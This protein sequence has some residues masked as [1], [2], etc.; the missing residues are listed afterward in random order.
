M[1]TWTQCILLRASILS[2][3]CSGCGHE[4]NEATGS[5]S[6]KHPE[7]DLAHF[8]RSQTFEACQRIIILLHDKRLHKILSWRRPLDEPLN[9]RWF[10]TD[11]TTGYT[12]AELMDRR[13]AF[14]GSEGGTVQDSLDLL[15]VIHDAEL[16]AANHVLWYESGINA[17]ACS[18]VGEDH[19]SNVRYLTVKGAE[20]NLKSTFFIA[21]STKYFNYWK[22]IHDQG[23]F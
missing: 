8:S 5:P 20:T 2:L 17:F 22:P 15:T 1:A 19:L 11:G 18:L 12:S 16:L 10:V 21:D 9:I 14:L 23:Q 6:L 13:H 7:L 3:V 4:R